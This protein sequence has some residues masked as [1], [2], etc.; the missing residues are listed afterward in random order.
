MPPPLH[1]HLSVF[2]LTRFEYAAA[3]PSS[4]VSVYIDKLHQQQFFSVYTVEFLIDL[5]H[6]H[7]EEFTGSVNYHCSCLLRGLHNQISSS[8][9]SSVVQGH[10]EFWVS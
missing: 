8:A 9:H 10:V 6:P 4:L 2:T 7:L 5:H 1:P 3:L